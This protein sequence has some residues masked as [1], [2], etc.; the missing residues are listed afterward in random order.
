MRYP[1]RKHGLGLVEVLI[2]SL[3][4]ILAIVPCISLLTTS[5]SE[6]VKARSR[7]IAVNLAASMVEEMRQ[8]PPVGR[9]SYPPV[10]AS[11]LP[12]FR[13]IVQAY[14]NSHP[15]ATSMS[16]V[17]QL[18]DSTAC[19]L[20]IGQTQGVPTALSSVEWYEAGRPKT[21]TLLG[22]LGRIP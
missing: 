6:T 10:A 11:D 12:Q 7:L 14:R 16:K 22:W 3:I 13:D 9:D 15:P 8:R 4:L 2:A 19:S 5:S 18:L 21:H 20:S 17:G 1:A